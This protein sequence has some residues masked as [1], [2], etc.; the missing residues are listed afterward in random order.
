MYVP[1]TEKRH[2]LMQKMLFEAP[3]N[4]EKKGIQLINA[5]FVSTPGEKAACKS[6]YWHTLPPKRPKGDCLKL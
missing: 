5:D 6:D 2:I 1:V 3:E 4:V